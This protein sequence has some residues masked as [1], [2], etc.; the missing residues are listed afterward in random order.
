MNIAPAYADGIELLP[1]EFDIE[2]SASGYQTYRRKHDLVTG[3][4]EVRVTLQAE[5]PRLSFEPKMVQIAGGCFQMGSPKTEQERDDDERQHEVCVKEAF[6]IGVY[7][8]TQG[9]WKAVMGSNPSRF[10]KGDDY[11]VENVS[12][13]GV[14]T[15]LSKLNQKTGRDYRLPTE[16]EWEYAAR[17]GTTG[18][19]WTSRCVTTDQANYDGRYSYGEPDCGA[20]TGV[21]REKTL[22]VGSFKPNPWGLYD[23]MGN[24][25]EWTC[26]TYDERY[27][28]AEQKCSD[29]DTSSPLAVRGGSW[30]SL[31]AWVRSANR[32][33]N[34][35]P[36]RGI[37]LGF[38]LARSL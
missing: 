25:W 11:P 32:D 21:Y 16:A 37:N 7:E 6:E 2:V 22:P 33:W 4:Q 38:R 35:P 5:P 10:K 8:V 30:D 36:S 17:A 31:P 26:S 29:K 20:K 14:Q 28:G 12:W 9:Q 27:G 24:V 34:D 19:F 3:P 18:P 13:S 1:G 15:Y 23:T